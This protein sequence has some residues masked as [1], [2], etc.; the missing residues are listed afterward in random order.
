MVVCNVVVKV[1]V[2]TPLSP[3]VLR[4]NFRFS[5]CGLVKL[6]QEASESVT[7]KVT[8]SPSAKVVFVPKP[9]VSSSW[10]LPK[11]IFTLAEFREAAGSA[12]TWSI[13]ALYRSLKLTGKVTVLPTASLFCNWAIT[14]K[15]LSKVGICKAVVL[16]ALVE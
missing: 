9:L 12:A 3:K 11:E 8:S 2:S 6:D 15:F 1:K 7:V 16:L 4:N 5:A 10:M 13:L 14:L